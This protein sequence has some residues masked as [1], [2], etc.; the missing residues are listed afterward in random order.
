MGWIKIRSWHIIR[1][2]S[3]VPNVAVTLCGK[4]ASGP[5]ADGFGNERSCETC[6]R[7]S[8]K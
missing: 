3:R 8:A 1:T 5:T 7:L 6:L 4:R 2:W